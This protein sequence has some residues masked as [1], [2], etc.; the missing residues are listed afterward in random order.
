MWNKIT[1]IDWE[2]TWPNNDG[3]AVAKQMLLDTYTEQECREFTEF[4]TECHVAL[5]EQVRAYECRHRITCGK[6][7]GLDS[8]NDMIAQV[9]GLGEQKFNAV[10]ANPMILGSV[11]FGESFMYCLPHDEDFKLRSQTKECVTELKRIIKETD[12]NNI[13][14]N[15]IKRCRLILKGNF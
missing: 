10:F 13:A 5:S 4:V 14:L 12:D 15:L 3:Y 7:I 11:E 1:E 9:I 6:Y 2:G 8:F